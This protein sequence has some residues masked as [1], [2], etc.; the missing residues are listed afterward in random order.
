MQSAYMRCNA[1]IPSSELLH[2]NGKLSCIIFLEKCFVLIRL[3][4]LQKLERKKVEKI[5]LPPRVCHSNNLQI[6]QAYK[7]LSATYTVV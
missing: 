3:N 1:K 2:F 6:E 7:K 4:V 5:P